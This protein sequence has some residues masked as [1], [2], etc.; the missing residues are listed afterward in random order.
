MEILAGLVI[1]IVLVL[2]VNPLVILAGSAVLFL[3]GVKG[4]A[5]GIFVVAVVAFVINLAL[6]S[7]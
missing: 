1:A 6:V 5:F 4:W 7:R 3:C 2:F